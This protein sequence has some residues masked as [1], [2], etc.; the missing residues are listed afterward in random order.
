[1]NIK[2]KQIYIQNFWYANNYGACLTAYA[3]YTILSDIGH[4]VKLIDV[5][6]MGEKLS[7][8]FSSFIQKHCKTT[9]HIKTYSDLTNIINLNSVYITGS[10]QVFRPYLVKDKL[11][12]FLF[13]YIPCEKKIAMSASFG[14]Y[15]EQFIKETSQDTIEKM[16]NSLKTFDKISV[17]EKDGIEI[18]NDIFG[19]NA[20]WIMDP[21]FIIHKSYFEEL[22]RKGKQRNA[23]YIASCIFEKKN[24]KIDKF[25]QKKYNCNVI[26]LHQSNFSIEDWLKTIKNC[27][28][29]ITNSYHAMCFA[30]IFNKPFIALSK[31]MGAS[32]RFDSI[33]ELLG[34]ENQSITSIDDIYTKNCVFNIDYEKVNQRIKEERQKGLAFLQKAL[35]SPVGKFEEKQ[36]V[37]TQYLEETI[38]KLEQQA[39]LR[40]QI[41]KELW[42]LWLIIFHKY[43]PESVKNI[44]RKIRGSK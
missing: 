3:L 41:K 2:S 11:S 42:N 36:A 44:I 7:Y 35:E 27:K 5:S 13:D 9:K 23:N 32:S 16:Q 31:D 30:I 8:M 28:F 43:L 22:T 24:N 37:R 17:R 12:K 29:L 4:N 26:E 34:I 21:V 18:C 15:K 40:Y 25:L 6:N 39:N 10:D 14:V 20:E 38:C 19:V 1:M 33:F